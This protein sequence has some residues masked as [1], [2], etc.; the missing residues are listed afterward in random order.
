VLQ[1]KQ[2]A[3]KKIYDDL[4]RSVPFAIYEW[5]A[6]SYDDETTN[7]HKTAKGGGLALG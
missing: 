2:T 3:S 4:S 5:Q 6:R 1:S 7:A